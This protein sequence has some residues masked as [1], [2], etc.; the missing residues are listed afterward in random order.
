MK[1]GMKT[2]STTVAFLLT[3]SLAPGLALA[4][5][6]KPAAA[7]GMDMDAM[8]KAATPG[9]HHKH[10]QHMVGDWTY[11]TRMWMAPGQPPMESTGT[12]HAESILGG[13]Y[14][15]STYKG[16]MMGQP[17]EGQST[18]GYDNTAGHFVSAWVDNMGTGIMNST[19][20]CDADCKVLTMLSDPMPD[21]ATGKKMAGKEVITWTDNN[22]F[23]FEM[24]MV[25]PAGGPEM[26]VMESVAKRK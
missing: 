10:L 17:F 15:R 24:F 7:P 22:N 18:D 11:T 26:K 19:G 12:M 23:K 4:Q 13:R 14:V 20:S 6:D 25:D 9:E 3:L 21:P 2:R 16:Q 8:A 5:T 1:M